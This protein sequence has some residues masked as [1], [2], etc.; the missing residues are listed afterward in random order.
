MFA[1]YVVL[2]QWA[3]QRTQ[4]PLG[5]AADQVGEAQRRARP[6]LQSQV[7][8]GP[9][10]A[11]CC[12]ASTKWAW[13]A[14]DDARLLNLNKK[15][16]EADVLRCVRSL[17]ARRVRFRATPRLTAS[18]GTRASRL[19]TRNSQRS[20]TLCEPS[21]SAAPTPSTA[22]PCSL[23]SRPPATYR[24]MDAR[25]GSVSSRL[26]V[27]HRT[28][29]KPATPTPSSPRRLFR[30]RRQPQEPGP[31]PSRLDARASA[32]Q[33]HRA[34]AAGKQADLETE[35]LRLKALAAK[36][37]VELVREKTP[38]P[39]PPPLKQRAVSNEQ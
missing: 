14:F 17:P 29:S 27:F 9:R 25:A 19:T 37:V 39:P 3:V 23:R 31:Q 11:R 8:L 21:S 18:S 30:R 20:R 16:H 24:R 36:S 34:R 1:V 2:N 5:E 38:P 7:E 13:P 4:G 28:M 15:R 33:R 35:R 32:V 12:A 26:A 10:C 6:V 22:T